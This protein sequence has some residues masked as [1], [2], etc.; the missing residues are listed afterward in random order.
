VYAA[1][2]G[3]VLYRSITLADLWDVAVETAVASGVVMLIVAFG[4]LYSWAG[5]TLGV[6]DRITQSLLGLS[7][8]P[9]VLLWI[10][11]LIVFAAGYFLDGISIFYI[12]LPI[13]M[14][15]VAHF[16]WS[17]VWF[18]VMMTV[19]IA[20]GQVT[21]PVAVNLY[22]A[23]NV[24]RLRFETIAAAVWPFVAAMVLALIVVILFPPL[25]TWLPSV[26]G[27]R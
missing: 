25:S 23:A 22:V 6:L 1:F 15:I 14:P 3:L 27:L 11:N 19:N 26:F 5:S 18:G 24:A 12:F 16:G 4:G 9:V 13:F 21:P 2:V 10:V 7:Q 17:P 8:S 20:I